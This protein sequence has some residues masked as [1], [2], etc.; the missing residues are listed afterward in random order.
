MVLWSVVAASQAALTGRTSFYVTR[1]LL[2]LIEGG[3]IPD[4]I[5]YLS[6][7]YKNAELPK[8]LSWFWTSYQS[9]Q[10]VDAFLV[11]GIIHLR[12]KGVL[13]E[14]WRYLFL[15]EGCLTGLIG[16]WTW[17]CLPASPTQT[18][19]TS[20]KGL[21]RPRSGWFFVREETIIVTRI[22]RDDPNKATMHN[23]QGLSLSRYKKALT[24]YG[25]WPIYLLGLT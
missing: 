16:I 25:L 4:T 17:L 11:Y 9:T 1:F 19:R 13:N 24:D 18:S 10:G 5:L 15:I 12:G 14:G 6:Y 2:G 23:R 8:R 22:L 7:F 20:F 3:F 21:F